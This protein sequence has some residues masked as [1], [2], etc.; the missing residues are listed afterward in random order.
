[1]RKHCY[2]DFDKLIQPLMGLMR[3]EYPNGFKL[4]I[5][6]DYANIICEQTELNFL[7]A[8]LKGDCNLKGSVETFIDAFIKEGEKPNE[9]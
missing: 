3:D 4:I 5:G 2:E 6:P 8:D 7:H 9:E 1:M